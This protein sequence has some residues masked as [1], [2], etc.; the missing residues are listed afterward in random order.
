MSE[1]YPGDEPRF[2][3]PTT[4]IQTNGHKAIVFLDAGEPNYYTVDPWFGILPYSRDLELQ[5]QEAIKKET[6]QGTR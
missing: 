1:D 4:S 3:I 2:F 5:L 6:E